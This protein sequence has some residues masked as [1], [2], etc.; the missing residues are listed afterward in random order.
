[1]SGTYQR[2]QGARRI[3]T[4]EVTYGTT[5]GSI[6]WQATVRHEEELKGSPAAIL[7]QPRHMADPAEAVRLAV[8][9][10]IEGL[11]DVAE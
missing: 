1:V 4:Y 3:Y 9:M 11:I 10:A 5:N 2:A 8:E 7:Y 6:E